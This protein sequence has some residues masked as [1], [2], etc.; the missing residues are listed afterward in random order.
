[1]AESAINIP[2]LPPGFEL[3]NQ[4]SDEFPPLPEGFELEKNKLATSEFRSYLSAAPK[5]FLTELGEQIRNLPGMGKLKNNP[6]LQTEEQAQDLL[7]KLL[8]TNK[9][10]VSRSLERGGKLATYA[11]F[12]GNIPANIGRSLLAGA[13]GEG[14][15]ESGLGELGQAGAEI[16]TLSGPDLLKAGARKAKAFVKATKEKTPSG[17]TKLRALNAKSPE[18]GIISPQRQE[19]VINRLNEEASMLA[20]STVERELPLAEKIE[21]GFDFEK[22]YEEGFGKLKQSAE[23]ANPVIDTDPISDFLT[24]EASKYRG[25][26]TPHPEA[27]KIIKEIKNFRSVSPD[28]L[29]NLLKIYRSNNQKIKNIGETARIKGKQKEYTDFLSDLNRKISQSFEKTLPAD[30]E[31]MKQF[32]ELNSEY[33]NYKDA[34]KTLKNLES[35]LKQKITPSVLEK[36]SNDTSVHKRLELSLGEKGT[37][38]IVQIS[39]DLKDARNAIKKIPVRELKAWE[40][41]LPLAFLVPTKGLSG[42]LNISK[43]LNYA[44]RGYGLLLTTPA[45]RKAYS[46]ALQ[47]IKEGSL[48]AYKRA[49]RELGAKEKEED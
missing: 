25:I 37:K 16:L 15:K 40:Q 11:P 20:K 28:K 32:K 34:Q 7:N 31:W 4:N 27:A 46:N 18:K 45:K 41:I 30:S 39:K 43:S 13:A 21:K 22:K 49:A 42:L 9:D 29:K 6:F 47:A 48:E 26:P 19:Q 14:A 8:P 36:L 24:V 2:P 12:G 33:K 17:L 10:F 1:M 5:G 23:K 3:E 35:L 38:E 44:R